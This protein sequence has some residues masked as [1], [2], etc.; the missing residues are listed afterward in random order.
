MVLRCLVRVGFGLTLV[1]SMVALLVLVIRRTT[2]NENAETYEAL[3]RLLPAGNCLCQASTVFECSACLDCAGGHASSRAQE[4]TEL[5]EQESWTFTFG[6]DDK[7]E[8][9]NEAQCNASFPGL[10]EDI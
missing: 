9:L 2:L 1:L 8:G 3:K 4:K 10:F 7:N 5:Q 6:R